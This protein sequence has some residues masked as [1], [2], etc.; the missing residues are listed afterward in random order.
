MKRE[1]YLE[2]LDA[3][4]PNNLYSLS[5]AQCKTVLTWMAR[6]HAHFWGADAAEK[7]S[8]KK[9]DQGLWAQGGY[10][11]LDTRREELKNAGYNSALRQVVAC[12]DVIDQRLK[13]T[14]FS[15]I[16][17]GDP[18]CANIVFSKDE[19]ECA[20]YD[21]QYTGRAPGT[22]DLAYLFVTSCNEDCYKH[23]DD[24]LKHYLKE[25]Q[26]ALLKRG[27]ALAAKGAKAYTMEALVEEFELS[28]LDFLRFLAGWGS[29][30]NVRWATTRSKKR[31]AEIAKAKT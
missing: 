2:D 23:E 21:F 29:W 4:Y 3:K 16:V 17:H 20:L 8:E 11:Y 19:K 22:K 27:D 15:T 12:A 30:G 31:L 24:L 13:D 10:W 14:P 28:I 18:K 7:E 5:V 26:T 6:Y 25:L 1:F 9:A